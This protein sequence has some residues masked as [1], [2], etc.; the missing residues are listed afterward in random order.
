MKVAKSYYSSG[1]LCERAQYFGFASGMQSTAAL[2][3]CKHIHAELIHVVCLL[4]AWLR[5]Q[6]AVTAALTSSL[7]HHIAHSH[8]LIHVHPLNGSAAKLHGLVSG[9]SHCDLANDLRMQGGWSQS[10]ISCSPSRLRIIKCSV[11]VQRSNECQADTMQA[12]T[13]LSRHNTSHN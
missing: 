11:V 2:L 4:L 5:Y 9:T 1:D 8:T 6:C 13:D 7:D 3:V 10:W 12:L